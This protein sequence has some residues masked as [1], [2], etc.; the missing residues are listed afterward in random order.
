MVSF[1]PRADCD[2][3]YDYPQIFRDIATKR[4]EE[5]PTLRALILKD[6]FFITYFIL[7]VPIANHPFVVNACKEVQQGSDN[8]TLDVWAR[9]LFKSTIITIAETIQYI[10]TDPERTTGIFSATRPLAKKFLTSIKDTF[11]KREILHR[12]FPEIVYANPRSEALLWSLDE[13][14]YM[15]R[16]TTRKEPTVSAHGLIEGMPTGAHYERRIYDDIICE[17]HGRSV[18]QMEKI[19]DKFDSSQNL[20]T[21]GG[22]HRVIGTFYHHEDP[23]C[24][25]RDK[26]NLVTGEPLY[27]M[28]KKPA[29]H[30]GTRTGK[31]VFLSQEQ[32]DALKGDRTFNC[33]QLLD[34]S[35]MGDRAYTGDMIHPI[36]DKF[37]PRRLFEIMLIDQAGDNADAKGDPWAIVLLGIAPESD[38]WGVSKL[39]IKDLVIDTMRQ[40]E[41]TAAIVQM[42][43]RGGLVRA[44]GVE[45]VGLSTTEVHIANALKGYGRRISEKHRNLQLLKPE[46]RPKSARVTG[47]LDWP[48]LNS[49]V[50]YSTSIADRYIDKLKTELNGFPNCSYHA[51]DALGY[52]PDML[53]DRKYDQ[54]VSQ[55]KVRQL[56]KSRQPVRSRTG[57]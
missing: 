22:R 7:E 47:A 49:K 39:Y 45:K 27:E 35:P 28:R 53:R 16:N 18:D 33:Q 32:L 13:G 14:L 37:I 19:K 54:R 5:L 50:Y 6:L 12:C 25:I 56:F 41:S 3:A 30:D 11:E 44:I 36:E 24:F 23:L 15:K 42:Y 52:Y 2:Y 43:L 57:Y 29:T 1:I 9:G 55:V 51:L 34:P 17:D 40:A 26:K 48:L 31:P 4:R 8:F 38:D 10:L 46:G 20:G 21:I